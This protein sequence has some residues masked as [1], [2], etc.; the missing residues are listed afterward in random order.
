[1]QRRTFLKSTVAAAGVAALSDSLTNPLFAKS[2]PA[3]KTKSDYLDNLGLQLWTVRFQLEDDAEGTLKAVKDAG[4]AQVELSRVIGSDDLIK[5][6]DDMGL[7]YTSSFV[8]WT[9]VVHPDR[10]DA[11]KLEDIIA[12]AK[13]WDI[14]HL[15]F[16]Y[17]GKGSRETVDQMKHV[18]EASNK[19]GEM[20][21]EADIKLCYHNHAFE[22]EKIDGDTTGFDVL[23]D[24][25][26]NDKC[27]FELDVFWAKI[28][29]WDPFETMKRLDG[30]ISQIH[31]KDLKQ[32]LGTI[33]D[34]GQ[35]PPDAYEE[36]GDG[37]I[38][39][40]KVMELAAEIG[41]EQCHVEQDRSPDPIWSIGKSME[42][43]RG[44]K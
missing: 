38:D 4:Y 30:R 22:F 24:N 1:M 10:K 18:A 12:Q 32:K 19:F 41:V 29:G 16:G 31:L 2:T 39:M 17:I 37:S 33:Y 44:I 6:C 25:F 13:K 20:C 42:Y 28:G 26:E 9:S 11:K 36:C 21:N 14:K 7:K 43:L 23:I 40:G 34:E 27:K 5:I 35:V 15:V 8:D 3:M